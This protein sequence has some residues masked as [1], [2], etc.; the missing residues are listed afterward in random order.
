MMT[1]RERRV[2]NEAVRRIKALTRKIDELEAKIGSLT[3][4]GALNMQ[5]EI[6]LSR[7]YSDTEFGQAETGLDTSLAEYIRKIVQ[8]ALDKGYFRIQK[9][10]HEDDNQGGD[11]FAAKGGYLI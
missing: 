5:S 10:T 3:S 8:K 11:A 6:G 4:Q 1:V 2:L 9:H 7:T